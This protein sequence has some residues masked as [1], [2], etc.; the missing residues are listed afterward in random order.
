[1]GGLIHGAR[2]A[3]PGGL[4]EHGNTCAESLVEDLQVQHFRLDELYW[5]TILGFSPEKEGTRHRQPGGCHEEEEG[6]IGQC[7]SQA[8]HKSNHHVR[9]LTG[10][11]W[12]T[13]TRG[14]S[15]ITLSSTHSPEQMVKA[16]VALIV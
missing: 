10:I 7:R 13:G 3:S 12:S 4:F 6:L 9:I 11:D 15:E 2:I 16:I 14:Q 5:L 8:L 1:M